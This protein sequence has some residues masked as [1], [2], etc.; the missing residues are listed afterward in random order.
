LC[1]F[2]AMSYNGRVPVWGFVSSVRKS[3]HQDRKKGDQAKQQ[4]REKDAKRQKE[5]E[6]VARLLAERW[7]AQDRKRGG[8]ADDSDRGPKRRFTEGPREDRSDDDVRDDRSDDDGRGPRR[9]ER[10]EEPERRR[11]QDGAD[12]SRRRSRGRSEDS[13]RRKRRKAEERKDDHSRADSSRGGGQPEGAEE[14]GDRPYEPEQ[15]GGWTIGASTGTVNQPMRITRTEVPKMKA[16]PSSHGSKVA[17][18]LTGIFGD[19]DSSDGEQRLQA[20]AAAAAAARQKRAKLRRPTTPE[21]ALSAVRAKQPTSANDMATVQ[22]KV[23]QWKQS[24]KGKAATMPEWLQAE[25][26]AVM[27]R[28][29]P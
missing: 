6:Q 7:A 26:A 14:D 20:E 15:G 18:A 25:V 5:A 2:L 9:N 19:D 3:S 11:Q 28:P 24:L 27:G 16:A 10:D 22:M 21:P 17:K 13:D 29:M 8:G 12:A 4:E 1:W 23:A